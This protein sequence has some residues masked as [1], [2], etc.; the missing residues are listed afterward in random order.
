MCRPKHR[1]HKYLLLL[2]V[3]LAAT[4]VV[5]LTF[6]GSTEQSTLYVPASDF[7]PFGVVGNCQAKV[8]VIEHTPFRF[9]ESLFYDRTINVYTDIHGYRECVEQI[10]QHPGGNKKFAMLAHN[11]YVESPIE[12]SR[13]MPVSASQGLYAAWAPPELQPV[14]IIAIFVVVFFAGVLSAGVF[15]ALF[16]K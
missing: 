5:P 6:V 12:S 16:V 3:I 11:R 7:L 14:R 4:A 13:A 8:A 15:R 1:F 9:P 2:V 10:H